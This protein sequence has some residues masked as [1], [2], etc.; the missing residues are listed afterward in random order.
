MEP[1]ITIRNLNKSYGDKR[2]LNDI[3]LDIN[4]GEI[5]GYI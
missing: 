1:I 4:K 3:N 2:V 5:I